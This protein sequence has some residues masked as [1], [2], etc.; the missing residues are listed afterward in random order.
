MN[1]IVPLATMYQ[2]LT[3]FNS[4]GFQCIYLKSVSDALEQHIVAMTTAL[5]RKNGNGFDLQ[6]M[7]MVWF[8]CFS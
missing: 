1:F 4:E 7:C 3:F 5:C 6:E 2:S 8:V